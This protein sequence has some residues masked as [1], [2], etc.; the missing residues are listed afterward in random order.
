LSVSVE[1]DVSRVEVRGCTRQRQSSP[2]QLTIS[3]PGAVG[4]EEP[5]RAERRVEVVHLDLGVS[6]DPTLST[7]GHG[8]HGTRQSEEVAQGDF[9]LLGCRSA[10]PC[11]SDPPPKNSGVHSRFNASWA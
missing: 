8:S 4:R 9:L 2:P 11:S 7:H 5:R 3:E 6:P 10:M 1:E